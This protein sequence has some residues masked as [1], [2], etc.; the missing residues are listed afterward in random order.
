M[1]ITND[2]RE[3]WWF[4]RPVQD[5]L[6]TFAQA[7]LRP[8]GL[9]YY[10]IF[11]PTGTGYHDPV[12]RVIH[13]NPALFSEEPVPVQFRATQGLLAHEAAHA[14]YTDAWPEA[15]EDLL[16]TLVNILEDQRIENAMS[17]IYPGI[18]PAL[19]LLGDMMWAQM[20][21]A[22]TEPK[23]QV[24]TC[25]LAWRW[26]HA[27]TSESAM[28]TK[29]KIGTEGIELWGKA[30]P[31]VESAWEA[32]TTVE[33]IEIARQLLDLI[34]L[35][36]TRPIPDW[37]KRL[38]PLTGV[39]TSRSGKP[40]APGQPVPD[41]PN[42]GSAELDASLAPAPHDRY[43]EP[44][45]YLELENAAAPLARRLAEALKLPDPRAAG[46]PHVWRGR[47]SPRQRVRTPE[48]AFIHHRAP[49]RTARSLALH[50]LVDRSGSMA[51][52]AEKVR[53]ALMM[54]YLAATSLYIPMGL[55][56]FGADSDGDEAALTFTLSPLATTP[57]ESVKAL[58]AG[59]RG[60]T[61]K[62]FLD[63]GLRAAEQ[64][65]LARSET[66]K[67]VLVLHD[68]QPVYDGMRGRDWDL[69]LQRLQQ[70]ELRGLLA[71]GIYLGNDE[72]DRH[73]L[74]QLFR[75]LI[76]CSGD[77]L[78]DKLGDVLRGLAM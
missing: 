23:W 72:D 45:P 21:G 58:I 10:I 64:E 76:V 65:L 59:Y 30:R 25:C 26:A 15:K 6:A 57:R 60:V 14:L 69:A 61:S 17:V 5:R 75:R 43:T 9:R 16:C 67:V 39:P 27:R 20:E 77:D 8:L 70:W 4:W 22:S 31:L 63:W 3:T 68:G 24:I 51:G 66:R 28:L 12:G 29:L 13:A 37:L 19:R 1:T 56:A 74:R 71:I 18:V 55:T 34:G 32:A 62:E 54:L 49:G 38:A 47:F 33:V 2:P 40:L 11:R 41:S 36:A 44:A 50:V 46:V 78:P 48:T 7:L 35:P 73:K 42:L 52:L 53:L